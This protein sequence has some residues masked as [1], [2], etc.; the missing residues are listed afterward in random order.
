MLVL[1]S[2]MIN[3]NRYYINKGCLGSSITAKNNKAFT[4]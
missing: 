4:N 2:N 1:I 3:I